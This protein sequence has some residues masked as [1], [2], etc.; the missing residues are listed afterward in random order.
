MV[1]PAILITV[2]PQYIPEQSKPI[3]EMYGFSYT[4]TVA[5]RGSVP[6]QLISRHWVI[7]DD[8][9]HVE[10]V[11][12]LGVVGHQPYLKPGEQFRY[13]SG[14][15]LRTPSGHMTGTFYFVDEEGDHF[16]VTVPRFVLDASGQPRRV[17]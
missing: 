9:G 7:S 12:G 17:H 10:E 15:R 14:C 13:S 2:E 8:D 16:G 3:E 1:K 5:N 4:I 6:A 11:K